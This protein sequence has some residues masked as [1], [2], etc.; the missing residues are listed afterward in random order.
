MRRA[1]AGMPTSSRSSIARAARVRLAHRQVRADRLDQLAAHRVQ[2]IERG[3]RILEDGADLAPADGAHRVVRKVVDAP[4]GEADLAFGDAAGRIDQADD[5]RAGQRLARAGFADDA[6]H[7]ARARWR[8]RRRRRRPAC[9]G[10]S[11]TRRAG[12]RRPAAAATSP[13]LLA[14]RRRRGT[15][16]SRRSSR[17]SRRPASMSA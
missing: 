16:R 14:R 1:A 2:R 3:Q 6:E 8:T 15:A 5:R 9:R 10:G 12:P 13:D 4:A 11:E 17:R 7:L